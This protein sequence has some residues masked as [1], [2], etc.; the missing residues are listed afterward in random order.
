MKGYW[1]VISLKVDFSLCISRVSLSH[2]HQETHT[3]MLYSSSV[4]NSN[5]L[6]TTQAKTYW[7]ICGICKQQNTTEIYPKPSSN[8][9]EWKK[10]I[11]SC[12]RIKYHGLIHFKQNSKSYTTIYAFICI[13]GYTHTYSKSIKEEQTKFREVVPFVVGG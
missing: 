13:Q 12:E 6:K 4:Y 8:T 11:P 3:R 1:S 5:N 10:N 9:A 7:T 2:K